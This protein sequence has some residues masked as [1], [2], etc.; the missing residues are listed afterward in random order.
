MVV[1][2][3]T[4]LAPDRIVRLV[5]EAEAVAVVYDPVMIRLLNALLPVSVPASSLAV[6][7]KVTL[8]L[9]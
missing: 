1:V 6:P 8:P 7:V 5:V 3:A 9:L 4:K 2:P